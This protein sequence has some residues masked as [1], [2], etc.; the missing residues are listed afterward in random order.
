[1]A[2][3]VIEARWVERST[4]TTLPSVP[5]SRLS[6]VLRWRPSAEALVLLAMP[7]LLLLLDRDWPYGS[8]IHDPWI[9]LGHA[10]DPWDMFVKFN[11]DYHAR[12]YYTSRL[13]IIMPLAAAHAVLPALVANFLVRLVLF[14]VSV[15]CVFDLLRRC[16]GRKTGLLTAFI[17]G[18]NFFFLDAI[19]RDYSDAF[20]IAYILA[21]IWGASRA[22]GSWRGLLAMAFAGASTV[23]LVSANLAYVILT[24]IPIACYAVTQARKRGGIGVA[25]D[26]AALAIGALGL[27]AL[28]CMFYYLATGE[29]WYLGPSI[30]FV[31]S[32]ERSFSRW[33]Y[34]GGTIFK[35]GDVA[36]I[37]SAV[38]LTLPIAVATLSS[39]FLL[40]QRVRRQVE[41]DGLPRVWMVL[42]LCQFCVYLAMD[43]LTPTGIFLQAWYYASTLI[44]LMILALG[45]LI[46]R[47]VESLDER[48]FR[49]CFGLSALLLLAQTAIPV[50]YTVPNHATFEPLLLSVTP[51]FVALILLIIM[52]NKRQRVMGTTVVLA[53]ILLAVSTYMM[54]KGFREEMSS[55]LYTKSRASGED[56]EL[57]GSRRPRT[58][59]EQMHQYDRQH[60]D[61]YVSIVDALRYAKSFDK[62][63]TL[64]FW[65]NLADPHAMVYENLT[66]CRNFMPSIINF[67]FPDLN[68][69]QK[70]AIMTGIV[71]GSLVAILSVGADAGENG[72]RSL[73]S[74]GLGSRLLGQK[75]IE[76]GKIRFTVH[77][78]G[79]T[80][81]DV[82]DRLEP[83]SGPRFVRSD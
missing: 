72:R 24:P 16:I 71:P 32:S 55:P 21:A 6:R 27:F 41:S 54:R 62:H 15:L 4:S 59:V 51:A 63:N 47:V 74:I 5:A 56:S 30:A 68:K 8:F 81:K 78:I 26:L 48:R 67:S 35:F 39:V 25:L 69:D 46:G 18:T 57:S 29:F 79:V 34:N 43:T 70:S 65:F 11:G 75:K 80:A 77:M 40:N 3:E 31:R 82:V 76:H 1:M 14:E 33:T 23:A 66:C 37:G 9:Y 61:F 38:W 60:G 22:G 52:S 49:V 20:A 19:G 7:W 45:S 42:L 10:I 2:S 12:F 73:A 50:A 28:F 64:V 53:A 13:S 58:L 44:P 17:L 36:W 83:V